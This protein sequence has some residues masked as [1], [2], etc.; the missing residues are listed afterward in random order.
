MA[1]T[2]FPQLVWFMIFDDTFVY[3]SSKKTPSIGIYR[4]HGSKTNRLHYTRGQ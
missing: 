4:Q 1:V 2:L 3:L